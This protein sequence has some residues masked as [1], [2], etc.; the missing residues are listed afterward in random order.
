[1]MV[2]KSRFGEARH[3][4]LVTVISSPSPRHSLTDLKERKC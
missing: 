3:L 1:M 2:T 4:Y